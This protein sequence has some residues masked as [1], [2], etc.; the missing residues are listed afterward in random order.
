[1]FAPFG[2]VIDTIAETQSLIG[3]LQDSLDVLS[4]SGVELDRLP[5]AHA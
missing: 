5:F 4:V 1:M 3:F 2:D